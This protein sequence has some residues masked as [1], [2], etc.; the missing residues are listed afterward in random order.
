[1]PTAPLPVPEVVVSE[2]QF[3]LLEAVHA[4]PGPAVTATV[5]DP[6]ADPAAYADG[7]I[8]YVQ[9]SDCVTLNGNP[10]IVS[11]PVRGGPVVGATVNEIAADPHPLA[12]AVMVIQ[13]ASDTPVQAQSGLEART[14]TPPDP[15]AGEKDAELLASVNWHC[16]A[17]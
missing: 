4:Q 15:P 7:A 16:E 6:P 14:S 3:A 5:A 12:P 11:V 8:A 2:T 9:P 1:M 13:S 17:A 10:A